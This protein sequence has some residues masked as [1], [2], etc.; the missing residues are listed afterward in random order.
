MRIEIEN[1]LRERDRIDER[2]VHAKERAAQVGFKAAFVHTVDANDRDAA[3]GGIYRDV[4]AEVHQPGGVSD[5]ER[6]GVDDREIA[7]RSV[8][9]L[10]HA[11]RFGSPCSCLA[12]KLIDDDVTND[13]TDSLQLSRWKRNKSKC[14]QTKA[15]TTPPKSV[16]VPTTASPPTPQYRN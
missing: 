4:Q 3:A 15:T 1:G 13:R 2:E 12:H 9:G 6:S 16:F 5:I 11:S 8:S 7:V 14:W 10:G